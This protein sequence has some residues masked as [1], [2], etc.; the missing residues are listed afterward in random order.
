MTSW[1][2]QFVRQ[3]AT[4]EIGHGLVERPRSPRRSIEQ[5]G[6][7]LTDR[8]VGIEDK[9]RVRV[10]ERLALR[11]GDA[12]DQSTRQEERE[13][14]ISSQQERGMK[15]DGMLV[16]GYGARAIYGAKNRCEI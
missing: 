11:V 3:S 7:S 14:S 13:R 10:G 16:A 12:G 5:D 6:P 1:R 8:D 9:P 4:H 15:G 2:G